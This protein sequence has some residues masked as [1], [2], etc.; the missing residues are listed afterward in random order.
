MKHLNIEESYSCEDSADYYLDILNEIIMRGTSSD[1]HWLTINIDRGVTNF[2][3]FKDTLIYGFPLLRKLTIIQNYADNDITNKDFLIFLKDLNLDEFELIDI[4]SQ[5][6]Q[7]VTIDELF[8]VMPDNSKYI[9]SHGNTINL[10]P[11]IYQKGTKI[12][13]WLYNSY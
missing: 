5:F 7:N 4:Q 6:I 2:Q 3:D 10:H 12:I 8:S 1:T 11:I 9:I 13:H